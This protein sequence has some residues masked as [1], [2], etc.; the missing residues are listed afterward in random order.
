MVKIVAQ[1]WLS[2]S[3]KILKKEA[4]EKY[5]TQINIQKIYENLLGDILDAL[6][7]VLG[8][9]EPGNFGD[10]DAVGREGRINRLSSDEISLLALLIIEWYFNDKGSLLSIQN[11]QTSIKSPEDYGLEDYLDDLDFLYPKFLERLH[12]LRS[13]FQSIKEAKPGNYPCWID[14]WDLC[15]RVEI[16]NRYDRNIDAADEKNI[17]RTLNLYTCMGLTVTCLILRFDRE[18]EKIKTSAPDTNKVGKRFH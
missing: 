14:E 11:P 16:K 10:P 2:K 8:Y 6:K 17:I 9:G 7:L 1:E 15:F 3:L 12:S 5:G 18:M 4:G 13:K